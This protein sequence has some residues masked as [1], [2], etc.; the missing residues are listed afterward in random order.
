LKALLCLVTA[1]CVSFG[2]WHLLKK[3][4][5]FIEV[6]PIRAG[7]SFVVDGRLIRLSGPQRLHFCLDVA[8]PAWTNTDACLWTCYGF[9]ERSGAFTYRV[10][11]DYR[12]HAP[13]GEYLLKFVEGYKPNKPSLFGR[14]VVRQR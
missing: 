7:E 3:Y 9:A 12:L 8:P 11:A 5:Q 4:G 2:S 13:P 6:R 1:V 10:H 14:L